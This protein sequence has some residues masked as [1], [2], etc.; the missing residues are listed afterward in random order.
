MS[1]SVELRNERGV[2]AQFPI[3]QLAKFSDRQ[4]EIGFAAPTEAIEANGLFEQ[5]SRLS[6]QRNRVIELRPELICDHHGS[7][8]QFSGLKAQPSRA[9]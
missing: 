8:A 9:E 3:D 7:A 6:A 4:V 5:S 2:L 1:E